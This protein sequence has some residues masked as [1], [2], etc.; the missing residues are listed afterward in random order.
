MDTYLLIHTHTPPPNT[1]MHTQHPR[2]T[3][4]VPSDWPAALRTFPTPPASLTQSL[5]APY[6]HPYAPIQLTHLH[7]VCQ[8]CV[9]ENLLTPFQSVFQKH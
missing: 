3:L 8:R 1:H 2:L 4:S 6:V 5:Q 7:R 9:M